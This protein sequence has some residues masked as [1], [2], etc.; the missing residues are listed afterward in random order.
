MPN[1]DGRYLI[2]V[3]ARCLGLHP[4]TLRKYERLGLITPAWRGPLRLYS[5]ADLERVR[6]IRALGK[7][8]LN[9]V[10]VHL[11]LELRDKLLSLRST[12]SHEPRVLEAVGQ[13]LALLDE[14]EGG[15]GS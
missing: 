15:G 4:W 12:C 3:A 14:D 5:D 10:G 13:M 9:L 1:Q 8:G 7:R 2:S 6:L 11:S